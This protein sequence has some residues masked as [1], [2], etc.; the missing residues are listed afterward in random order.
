MAGGRLNS[1][2]RAIG[3]VSLE[4]FGWEDLLRC[5]ATASSA[6]LRAGLPLTR[7]FRAT[8]GARLAWG[9]HLK[10]PGRRL[11]TGA[12]PSDDDDIYIYIYIYMY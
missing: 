3:Q 5:T 11:A 6:T 12:A 4:R 1:H 8:L 9:Q 2:H 7:G 10:K